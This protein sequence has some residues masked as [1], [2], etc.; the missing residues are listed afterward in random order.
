M[1]FAG[2]TAGISSLSLYDR[3]HSTFPTCFRKKFDNMASKQRG[4]KYEKISDA[5][6][7]ILRVYFEQGMRS[8][9]AKNSALIAKASEE[10]SLSV[11]KVKVL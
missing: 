1:R 3:L 2:D 6:K 7:S 9:A 11:E 4:E 8:T 10:A 5:Q